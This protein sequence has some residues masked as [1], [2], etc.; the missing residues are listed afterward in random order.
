MVST[1]APLWQCHVNIILQWPRVRYMTRCHANLLWQIVATEQTW[2]MLWVKCELSMNYRLLTVCIFQQ[3]FGTFRQWVYLD[4][5]AKEYIRPSG[6]YVHQNE[7]QSVYTNPCEIY[8]KWFPFLFHAKEEC[9]LKYSIMAY[10]S[11]RGICLL[12]TCLPTQIIFTTIGIRA[13]ISNYTQTYE[14]V[15]Y[16]CVPL[17]LRHGWAITFQKYNYLPK[18]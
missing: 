5:T 2:H 9:L 18:A 17:K 7:G 13:R 16:P 4:L 14:N 10:T 3:Q 15:T 8:T 11:P 1:A 12:R 6:F